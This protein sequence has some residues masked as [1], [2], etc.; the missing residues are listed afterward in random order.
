MRLLVVKKSNMLIP[1][2]NSDSDNLKKCKLKEGET[3]EVTIT[4]KRNYNFHKKYYALLNLCFDN[5][6]QFK[7]LDDLRAYI[8]CKAGYYRRIDTGNGMMI[9]PKSISFSNM[10]DIEFSELYNKTLD[11]ICT[12][13]G[14][15]KDD[16]VEELIKF[17]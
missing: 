4:R 9:F 11:V 14:A 1:M 16:L 10:D 13:L 7:L 15:D 17:M 5:Q 3:Y 2:Y 12:Y 6:S 8:T